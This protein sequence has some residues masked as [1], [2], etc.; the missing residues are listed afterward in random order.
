ML[1][2]L[3]KQH[4]IGYCIGAEVLFLGV[5]MLVS[6]LLTLG[7]VLFG[8]D[9]SGVEDYLLTAIQELAGVGVAGVFL[10]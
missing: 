5:L 7:L 1:K 9:L 6:F 4:P 2:R 10:G 8:S 3:R